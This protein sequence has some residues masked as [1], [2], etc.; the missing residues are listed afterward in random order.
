VTVLSNQFGCDSVLITQTSLLPSDS[1]FFTAASCNPQDTGIQVTVLSN[2]FIT[3]E[4]QRGDADG[5]E[6]Q[7]IR[8]R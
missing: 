4:C 2:Q 7:S 5:A 8:L 3:D 1:L 6:L